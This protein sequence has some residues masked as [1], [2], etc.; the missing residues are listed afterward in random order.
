MGANEGGTGNPHAAMQ[1][2]SALRATQD[3]LR[4][5][6]AETGGFAVVDNNDLPGA[7]GRVMDDQRGYYLVG[8][9]PDAATFAPGSAQ[10]FRKL[11]LKVVRPGLKVR[12]RAGFYGRPTE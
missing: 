3:G 6:A 9:Q 7:L 11:K 1:R 2:G 5:V 4:F 12:A 10:E 8:Y